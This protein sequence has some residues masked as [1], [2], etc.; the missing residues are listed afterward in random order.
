MGLQLLATMFLD[1]NLFNYHN[2]TLVATSIHNQSWTVSR[3]I[4]TF[5]SSLLES[6]T[7]IFLVSGTC[8]CF[9]DMFRVLGGVMEIFRF[10]ERV[11]EYLPVSG[12]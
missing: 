12:M 8:S 9:S 2:Y 3:I 6:D 10:P 11:P 1:S 4:S 5:F 7:E